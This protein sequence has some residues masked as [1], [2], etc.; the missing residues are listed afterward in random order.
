MEVNKKSKKPLFVL[1]SRAGFVY[2]IAIGKLYKGKLRDYT[3]A[4]IIANEILEEYNLPE[5]DGY[6]I[7]EDFMAGFAKGSLKYFNRNEFEDFVCNNL[8][9]ILSKKSKVIENLEKHIPKSRLENLEK[10]IPKSKL[11]YLTI[12]E[13]KLD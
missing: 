8:D 13:E 10:Q 9:I 4:I 5:D 1:I 2:G 3:E 12:E 6:D 11:E 7:Y